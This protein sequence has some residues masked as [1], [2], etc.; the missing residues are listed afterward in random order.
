VCREEKLKADEIQAIFDAVSKEKR[1]E[2]WS[3][4]KRVGLDEMSTGKGKKI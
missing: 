4:V 3:S 1:E 2:K